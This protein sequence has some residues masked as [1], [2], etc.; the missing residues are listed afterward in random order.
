MDFLGT[1]GLILLLALAADA[2]VLRWIR[3][4][5][6]QAGRPPGSSGVWRQWLSA[7]SRPD[8]RLLAAGAFLPDLIDKPIGFWIAPDL[9]NGALRSFGHRI[10]GVL[11]MT[12]FIVALWPGGRLRS[13][14]VLAAGFG[15]H[16][17]S[18]AMWR[19]PR[20]ALWPFLGVEFPEGD[21][22]F[23][24]WLNR[25]FQTPPRDAA[26]FAGI[27]VLLAFFVYLAARKRISVFLRE[28]TV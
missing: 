1:V 6:W 26:E 9:V 21:S 20:V 22:P 11:V 13:L 8:Y 12:L 3:G 25:H 27:A 28:G 16:L 10:T 24:F 4:R 7:V 23:Q 2:T 5:V 19:Q 18:D 14:F 15:A 17:L